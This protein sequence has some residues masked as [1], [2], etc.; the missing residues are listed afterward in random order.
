LAEK[1]GWLKRE[2]IVDDIRLVRDGP[3]PARQKDST[4]EKIT[5]IYN[6]E[7][8]NFFRKLEEGLQ[9]PPDL[10]RVIPGGKPQ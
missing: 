8:Y 1:N 9:D 5:N 10:W 6:K 3:T 7:W 2:R 4:D